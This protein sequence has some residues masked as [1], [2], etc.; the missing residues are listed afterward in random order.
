MLAQ[1]EFDLLK[2]EVLRNPHPTLA[3]M[4]TEAPLYRIPHMELG[5]YPWMLTRYD[6]A[7]KVLNDD[8]F[9]KDDARIPGRNSDDS[10]PMMQAAA[11]INRH[12]LTLDPPDHTRLRS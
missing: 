2:P 8:R 4:R 7:I 1:V 9:T 6:D 10:D 11:A 12:V 5:A 3:V